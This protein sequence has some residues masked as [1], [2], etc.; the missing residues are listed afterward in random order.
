MPSFFKELSKLAGKTKCALESR[1]SVPRQPEKAL[2]WFNERYY[3]GTRLYVQLLWAYATQYPEDNLTTKIADHKFKE[4]IKRLA[5]SSAFKPYRESYDT[6][7]VQLIL[8]ATRT[9]DE[10][11]LKQ[12]L[13]W[14]K[15]SPDAAVEQVLFD[16][17]QEPAGGRTSKFGA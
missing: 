4:T 10:A 3:P 8:K 15:A 16:L 13:S 2:D 5:G 6:E 12:I 9:Y 11:S 7:Q 17:G 1:L 14:D